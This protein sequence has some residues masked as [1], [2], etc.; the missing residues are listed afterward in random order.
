MNQW[1]EMPKEKIFFT[2][3]SILL[4]IAVGCN[5]GDDATG[6][7]VAT[8]TN[9]YEDE[10]QIEESEEELENQSNETEEMEPAV[11][12]EANQT[13]YSEEF[14]NET[15]PL[16]EEPELKAEKSIFSPESIVST[17]HN[18]SLSLD[19][20]KHEIKSEY[21][22]KIIEITSTV[23]NNGS[24]AF[25]PKL[26]VILYDERDFK[27]EWFKTKAEIEF[28]VQQLNVR[29]HITRQAIVNVA[30]DDI[31]LPK[32]FKLVLVDAADPG[33]KPIVVVE[34]QFVP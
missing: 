34:K 18:V 17:Q 8:E 27:E 24:K 23:F 6:E 9:I 11:E 5:S 15:Y 19:N 25:K 21:W 26:L 22:G 3:F 13:D 4:I 28:D 32:N 14:S 20:M 29:E 31:A 1:F 33:N 16:E 10:P 12:L 30:F 2:L 7:A